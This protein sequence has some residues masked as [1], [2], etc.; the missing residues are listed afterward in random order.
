[1]YLWTFKNGPLLLPRQNNFLYGTVLFT[2]M[3]CQ[4]FENIV[5]TLCYGHTVTV[6]DVLSILCGFELC[7]VVIGNYRTT[8]DVSLSGRAITKWR[9]LQ[10]QD[11][12]SS[13]PVSQICCFVSFLNMTSCG[14]PS[15]S[16]SENHI[17][18][19]PPNFMLKKACLKVQNLQYNFGLKMTP[20][21]LFSENSSL[22]EAPP[23]PDWSKKNPHC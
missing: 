3:Q 7:R 8:Q 11:F 20:P 16:F 10:L 22:L 1:M 23:I 17:V 12:A 6:S 15:P 2:K 5:E 9:L 21:P 4:I 14:I 19:F 18:F 13:L